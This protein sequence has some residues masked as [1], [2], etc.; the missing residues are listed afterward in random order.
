MSVEGR[1]PD[2]AVASAFASARAFA[3]PSVC[4]S[5]GIPAVEAMSF[6]TPVVVADAAAMPEVVGDAGER[7]RPD[8]PADL[9]EKLARVLLD[10]EHAELL[11]RRAAERVAR[12]DWADAAGR[13]AERLEAIT[14]PGTA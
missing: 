14:G 4:E 3:L 12:Y 7:C 5:F 10:R 9:A 1:L 2:A 6:G 8:D 13:M 11:R